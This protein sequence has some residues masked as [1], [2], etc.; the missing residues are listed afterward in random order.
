[1]TFMV[2]PASDCLLWSGLSAGF[3]PAKPASVPAF[4]RSAGRAILPADSLSAGQ[5]ACQGGLPFFGVN[6]WISEF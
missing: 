3:Q 1:M 2:N 4:F 6:Q 5:A